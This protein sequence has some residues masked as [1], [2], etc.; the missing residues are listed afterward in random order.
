VSVET[1]PAAGKAGQG[2]FLFGAA[3][4]CADVKQHIDVYR[5]AWTDAGHP[6]RRPSNPVAPV[7]SPKTDAAAQEAYGPTLMRHFQNKAACSPTPLVA[8]TARRTIR[9]GN[10]AAPH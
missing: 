6:G 8:K 5:K 3:R 4:G 1:F 7:S 9:D 10:L 2:L